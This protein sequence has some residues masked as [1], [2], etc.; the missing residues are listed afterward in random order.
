MISTDQALRLLKRKIAVFHYLG[1]LC[2]PV[3]NHQGEPD[4]TLGS[5]CCG[6]RL[7]INIMADS[8]V[9]QTAATTTTPLQCHA[10]QPRHHSGSPAAASP[11]GE[12]LRSAP[13]GWLAGCLTD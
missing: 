11:I 4:P 7:L 1:T 12:G 2:E 5:C 13:I 3:T 6:C 9:R 10:T 8:P